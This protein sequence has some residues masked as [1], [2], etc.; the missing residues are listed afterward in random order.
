MVTYS[1]LVWASAACPSL[2]RN[3]N[4]D[5]AIPGRSLSSQRIPN[6]KHQLAYSMA[7]LLTAYASSTFT[8]ETHEDLIVKNADSLRIPATSSISPYH[9]E[10]GMIQGAAGQRTTSTKTLRV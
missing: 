5:S 6:S 10:V 4:P 1:S 8:T 9:T 7:A 3:L 2:S